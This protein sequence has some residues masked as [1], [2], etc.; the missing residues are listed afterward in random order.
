MEEYEKDSASGMGMFA[1][2]N[3]E[4]AVGARKTD[5]DGG[6]TSAGVRIDGCGSWV[7]TALLGLSVIGAVVGGF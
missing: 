7:V 3:T 5:E 6:Y 2:F 4:K 1:C